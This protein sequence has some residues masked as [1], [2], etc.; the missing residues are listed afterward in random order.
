MI[1]NI[2]MALLL[3]CGFHNSSAQ[4]KVLIFSKTAGFR[5][6]SIPKGAATLR[7]LLN[8]ESI[9]SVHS[10]DANYISTD[11]LKQFGAVIFL[12]T[13]GS[14]LN[15]AQKEA[16]QGFI[17]SG[18]GFVG[19]HAASDTEYEWPWYGQLVGGYFKSHPAVQEAKLEV[20]NAKHLSTKSLPK[21]WIH[22]DEWYD[23]KDVQP[24]LHILMTI[25]EQ[26]Y[27]GG[28]M[29]KFHPVAWFHEFEGGRSFYTGLGHTEESYD[30]PNFQKH[31]VG[32]IRY[33]LGLKKDGS[34]R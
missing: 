11:S 12:S 9:Q 23:Y 31:L 25:D 20:V 21:T 2:C 29:G 32:G 14:I 6:Q 30:V 18:K 27:K 15:T 33:A 4:Q 13:T 34:R 8:I 17:R 3:L 1:R 26:S 22:R 19:I 10:E 28:Q 24:G 5:H 16:L 7:D